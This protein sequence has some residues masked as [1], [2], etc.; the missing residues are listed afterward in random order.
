MMPISGFYGPHI[1]QYTS[2]K[3]WE[4]PDYLID[5]YYKMI[6]ES[7]I[8]LICY[9]EIDYAE[10]PTAVIKALQLAEK[11]G[12]CMYVIDRG[13]TPEMSVDEMAERMKAYNG[14]KSFK[15]VHICDEPSSHCYGPRERMLEEYSELATKIHSFPELNG[16]TNLYAFHPNWIGVDGN[17]AWR[18]R[19][20]YESYADDY[21]KDFHAKMLSQ[22]YYVFDAHSVE[23][24][25]DYFENLEIMRNTAQK[26]NIPFWICI[27]LG[28]Q[29]NDA[30]EEKE[31]KDY[32]PYPREVIW[33]VNTA[34][35]CG[36]KG[37][38]Y[39]PL[40][41]PIHFAYALE[42]EMDFE[43]NGLITA[44]GRK[45][46]WF[47]CTKKANAQIQVVG[48]YLLKMTQK[49][50]V[51][52]GH[53]AKLNLPNAVDSYGAL[54]SVVLGEKDNQYGAIVGCFE[55][56]EKDAFYI[57][58]NDVNK[59]QEFTLQLDDVY[60]IELLADGYSFETKANHCKITLE[61]SGACLVMLK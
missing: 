32:Y 31:S 42:G 29:W 51:V 34:L 10:E 20:C 59:G 57:V 5:K 60:D 41:Q 17:T 30:E 16:Y 13:L 26:H 39:F 47:E 37:I 12:L 48:K 38:T 54:K 23:D 52:Q 43:R 8:N 61:P 50:M 3:G 11:Y 56:Q 25:K 45:S 53:Y 28:G 1:W 44:D 19:D 33:N 6:K 35:A 55:Y 22:D 4:S 18:S 27:Q 58:N 24:S 36:A 14:F 49:A 15:G 46:R 21:C 9:T 7:G 40:L 2:P